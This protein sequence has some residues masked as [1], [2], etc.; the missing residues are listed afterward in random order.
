MRALATELLRSGQCETFPELMTEV[1]RRAKLPKEKETGSAKSAASKAA[2]AAAVNGI[3]TP[4]AMNGVN[5]NGAIV[6]SKEWSGGPDGLP[7]VRLPEPTVE[8][9]VEFLKGRIKEAVEPLDD[10]SD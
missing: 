5:G 9:G 4:N 2:A 3:G 7:D 10:D 1:L 8:A 6:L